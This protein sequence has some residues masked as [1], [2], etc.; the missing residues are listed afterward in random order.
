MSE[1]IKILSPDKDIKIHK[2]VVH[3]GSQVSQGTVLLLYT[4]AAAEASDHHERIMSSNCGIVKK[5]L[6]K[7]GDVVT[8]R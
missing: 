2:W 8:K 3:C 5:L 6:Y 1:S 4:D 7:E